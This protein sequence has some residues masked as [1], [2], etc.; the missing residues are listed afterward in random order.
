MGYW[1]RFS[2]SCYIA[3][4]FHA[5]HQLHVFPRL[6]PVACFPAIL[7]SVTCLSA[8]GTGCMFSRNFGISCMSLRAWHR[9]HVFT[10]LASVVCFCAFINCCLFFPR[11]SSVGRAQSAEREVS[12]SNPGQTNTH[13]LEIS[14]NEGAA[15]AI[16]P[17]AND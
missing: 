9:L 1:I 10:R 5:W 13:G 6:T 14:E 7:A 4:V 12:D 17:A 2:G 11:I 8:L 15:F 16:T 3:H